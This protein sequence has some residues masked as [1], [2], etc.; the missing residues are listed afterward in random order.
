MRTVAWETCSWWGKKESFLWSIFTGLC[1]FFTSYTSSK[2]YRLVYRP[3]SWVL[4]QRNAGSRSIGQY[5]R[6]KM[7]SFRLLMH[8]ADVGCMGGGRR[9]QVWG[10]VWTKFIYSRVDWK[11]NLKWH[12]LYIRPLDS[13]S[14]I[15]SPFGLII[16][17]RKHWRSLFCPLMPEWLLIC[18]RSIMSLNARFDLSHPRSLCKGGRGVNSMA[19]SRECYSWYIFFSMRSNCHA[20]IVLYF[21]M[22]FCLH[23]CN[24]Y[25]INT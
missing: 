25:N 1:T 18:P 4:S 20:N 2:D 12:S 6:D 8:K 24:I 9:S 22:N 14:L 23:F 7:V 11:R 10:L 21:E 15:I 16:F 3:E 17:C 5:L 19:F 13:S